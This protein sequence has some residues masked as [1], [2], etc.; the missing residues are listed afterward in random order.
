MPSLHILPSSVAT[1]ISLATKLPIQVQREVG[2]EGGA[3]GEYFFFFLFSSFCVTPPQH[4]ELT[5]KT[6]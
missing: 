5:R 3:E 2:G 1:A 4:T 6:K